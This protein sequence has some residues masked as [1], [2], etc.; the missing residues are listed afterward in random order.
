MPLFG[1]T[2][3]E[4]TSMNKKTKNILLGIVVA[5]VIGSCVFMFVISPLGI[6]K[7]NREMPVATSETEEIMGDIIIEQKFKNTTEDIREIAVVFSRH[8]DIGE[9]GDWINIYIELLD[10]SNVLASTSIKCDDIKGDHRTFIKPSSPI[11]GYVGKE[12][13]LKIYTNSPG[14]TGLSIMINDSKN[15]S[16]MFGGKQ[17]IGTM[18]FSITGK[19]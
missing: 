12:L 2:M 6:K 4:L 7:G 8:Y 9:E 5:L 11:H 15:M 14:G 17:M 13:S 19:E 18:C 10:G 16:F 3:V 1:A